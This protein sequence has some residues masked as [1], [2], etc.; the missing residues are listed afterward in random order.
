[1]DPNDQMLNDLLQETFCDFKASA[2][3][4][5]TVESLEPDALDAMS[6]I[7]DMTVPVYSIGPLRILVDDIEDD[8]PKQIRF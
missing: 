6:S 2:L 8:E 1:M 3:I 7:I 4:L 5:D